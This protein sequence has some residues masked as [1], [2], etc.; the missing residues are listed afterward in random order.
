MIFHSLAGF[1]IF[2]IL[3]KITIYEDFI[4]LV[5]TVY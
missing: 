2:E 4:Q 3:K 5:K 1:A